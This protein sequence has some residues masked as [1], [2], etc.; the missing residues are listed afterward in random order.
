MRARVTSRLKR[1]CGAGIAERFT[2]VAAGA[3]PTACRGRSR[4][5]RMWRT[6]KDVLAAPPSPGC[7][8]GLDETGRGKPALRT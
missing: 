6:C 3:A 7:V 5:G 8:L 1:A 4:T 2:C